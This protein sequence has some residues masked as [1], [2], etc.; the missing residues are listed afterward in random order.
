MSLSDHHSL[1]QA[2]RTATVPIPTNES[3]EVSALGYR[4]LFLNRGQVMNWT[5]PVP[6]N[7][8]PINQ[9]ANPE[10]IT[11]ASGQPVE[12]SQDIQVRYLRAPT[13]QPHG[14][15]II[16]QQQNTV[17]PPAPPLIIRQV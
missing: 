2:I 10:V 8:Y 3:E 4:G 13:P 7:K 1:E 14:D 11:K 15:I 12:Y 6:I 16:R 17:Y 9:D 5:G